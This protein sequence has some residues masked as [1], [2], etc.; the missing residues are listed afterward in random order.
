M[1]EVDHQA[2]DVTAVLILIGHDHQLAVTQFQQISFLRVLLAVVQPENLHQLRH[3]AVF[4]HFLRRRFANVQ[5]FTFERINAVP[6]ASDHT[7]TGDGQGFGRVSFRDDQ[8]TMN[9][10]LRSGVVR[11]VELRNAAQFRR[12][13][14]ALLLQ[15]RVLTMFEPVDHRLDDAGLLD[16]V[17]DER[18]VVL[19]RT[20]RT[21]MFAFGGQ[22]FLRLRFEFG[23]FD[24][25]VDEDEQVRFHLHR[26]RFSPAVLLFFLMC[27]TS[28]GQTCSVM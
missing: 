6:I 5:H 21:E 24:Q 19:Q 12:F 4:G 20:R 2:L 23:I 27:S 14:S 3:F 28:F 25:T 9:G 13:R 11:V 16:D 22:L 18:L 8:S 7:E 1:D 10:I 26:L 15:F 17:F